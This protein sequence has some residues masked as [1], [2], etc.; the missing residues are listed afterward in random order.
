MSDHE[1]EATVYE[2]VA[3]L[4]GQFYTRREIHDVLQFVA[5]DIRPSGGFER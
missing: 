5:D 3:E 1:P 4:E 2:A